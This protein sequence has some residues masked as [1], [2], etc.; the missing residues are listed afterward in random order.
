MITMIIVF[1]WGRSPKYGKIT[2]KNSQITMIPREKI[3]YENDYF[4]FYYPD[5]YLSRSE[6][7][8]FWLTGKTG[9]NESITVI[10]KIFDAS[11]NEDSGVKM[12]QVQTERYREEK[13]NIA[14]VDGLLFVKNDQSERTF[15]VKKDKVLISFSMMTI[16]GVEEME[17]KFSEII[18][19]WQ[20]K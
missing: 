6:G 8:V 16:F 20:W 5:D 10:S 1:Y 4:L 14:G 13:I 17:K 12:R 11:I 15:F 7:E 9:I 19:S 18:G 3:K 2:V